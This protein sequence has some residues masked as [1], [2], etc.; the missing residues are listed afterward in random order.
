MLGR[1]SPD[2]DTTTAQ[3]DAVIESDTGLTSHRIREIQDRS[4]AQRRAVHHRHAGRCLGLGAL[5]GCCRDDH[6]RQQDGLLT[7]A[8]RTRP[9]FFL[10]CTRNAWDRH[11]S[12]CRQPHYSGPFACPHH[13]I[14]PC[15]KTI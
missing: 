13:E 6:C 4:I 10:R 12:K 15:L 14:F 2:G 11:D 9:A 5:R 3:A 7:T 8:A 1:H